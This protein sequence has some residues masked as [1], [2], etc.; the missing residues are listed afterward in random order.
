MYLLLVLVLAGA[1]AIKLMMADSNK[2]K[3]QCPSCSGNNTRQMG[4]TTRVVQ[5]GGYIATAGKSHICDSC[6]NM[7]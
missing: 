2:P 7:F 1:F 6:G 4:P 5:G 3:R